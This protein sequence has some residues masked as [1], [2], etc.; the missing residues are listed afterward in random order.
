MYSNWLKHT[1]DVTMTVNNVARVALNKC[2]DF[3]SKAK[4]SLL[5]WFLIGCDILD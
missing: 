4:F 3:W 1:T 2:L 5:S